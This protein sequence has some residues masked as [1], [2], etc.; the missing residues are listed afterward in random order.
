MNILKPLAVILS[1]TLCTEAY[2]QIGF[3]D[4]LLF[5]PMIGE[6]PHVLSAVRLHQPT[7][8]VPASVTVLDAQFIKATGA[9]NIP[10]LF[11]Y[12]PGMLVVPEPYDNSDSIVYHGGPA[13]YPKS[14]EVLID[15]RAAYSAGLSAVGWNQL[16]VTVEEI[17]RIEVVRGPSSTA[18]GTNAYQSV[19]NI[20]TKH[21]V[22]TVS[23]HSISI[24]A[25]NNNDH[26]LKA[27]SGFNFAGGQW[28]VNAVDKGTDHLQD[29]NTER[30][31]CDPSCPD[32]RDVNM[33][34]LRGYYDLSSNQSLDTAIIFTNAKRDLPQYILD[35]NNVSEEKIEVGLR[36]FNELSTQ[37]HIQI[38]AYGYQFERDQVQT[39][40]SLPVGYSDPDLFELFKINPTAAN[41]IALGEAPTAINASNP[42]EIVLLQALTLKYVN[43]VDFLTPLSGVSYAQTEEIRADIELQ[44]TYAITPDLT[45]LSGIG[46]R[47]DQVSSASYYGRT[48]TNRSLR[49]F[50]NINW[51]ANEKWAFHAG[52]MNENSELDSSALSY[53][54]AAN[55]L[56]SSIE[57]LRFVYSRASKNPDF[58]EQYANWSYKIDN[59]ETESPYAGEYFYHTFVADGNL[60]SQH[61]DSY[62]LGY[63]GKSIIY[64]AEWDIR[65]YYENLS[66]V[67]YLWPAILSSTAYQNN[68]IK[69]YGTELQF[70]KKL[71]EHHSIRYTGSVSK[72]DS[73][74]EQGV[75][76][77]ELLAIYSPLSQSI[78]FQSEIT[79]SIN[80]MLS[81]FWTKDLG[82]PSSE[83]NENVEFKR[84]HLNIYGLIDVPS[85]D[86]I[87]W[88]LS[89]QHDLSND[90]SIQHGSKY[91]QKTRLQLEL[92]INF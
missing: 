83:G 80:S 77:E 39:V 25:G 6:V 2:A 4:E 7:A 66:N 67:I 92:G 62:E 55:Y 78:G 79:H 35:N 44:D 16:A 40:N 50:G 74:T 15:G 86:N 51:R 57:S 5:D 47:V 23:E 65:L 76:E 9:K 63:Y 88:A 84:M 49:L 73:E 69:F 64:D 32:R 41:Q 31:N 34:N 17:Q 22:D 68:E 56:I 12:V 26:Y 3:D 43:P 42:Q 29:N 54:A 81:L 8:E 21:P 33:I 18:Y 10:D 60:K 36:Y 19:V 71:G 24:Q 30:L 52:L 46:Y 82:G 27:Q 45:L 53:R 28:R 89:L 13:L 90:P 85:I 61:I 70:S 11:R 59:I 75:T 91:L 87:S 20:I 48:I 14:M 37:H 58:I 1:I 38:S 72:A